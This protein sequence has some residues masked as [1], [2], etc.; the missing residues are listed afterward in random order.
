MAPY[1]SYNHIVLSTNTYMHYQN[2]INNELCTIQN[3]ILM[4]ST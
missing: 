1:I 2:A 3:F 4:D